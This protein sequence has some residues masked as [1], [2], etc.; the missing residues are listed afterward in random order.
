[1]RNCFTFELTMPA[2]RLPTVRLNAVSVVEDASV[3]LPLWMTSPSKVAARAPVAAT[4]WRALPLLDTAST[5]IPLSDRPDTPMPPG[6]PPPTPTPLPL[7]PTTPL[8]SPESPHTP[9]GMLRGI[10]LAPPD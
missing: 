4:A 8:P 2:V 3:T 10:P 6:N 5:P 9:H 1:M 7:W